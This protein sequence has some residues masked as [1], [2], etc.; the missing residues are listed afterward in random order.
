[1]TSRHA[2]VKLAGV[3]FDAPVWASHPFIGIPANDDRSAVH[4][5]SV[6]R[7]LEF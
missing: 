6:Y 4:S 2:A 1:M 5:L 7:K 3:G